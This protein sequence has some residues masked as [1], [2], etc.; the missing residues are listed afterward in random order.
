M[1][2]IFLNLCV[3]SFIILAG[4]VSQRVTTVVGCTYNESKNQTDYFVIPFGSVSIPGKWDKSNYNSM[5]GQQFFK[6]NDSISIAIAFT[7]YDKYE[8]NRDGK[9]KGFD[10]VSAYYE[11]DSKYFVDSYGLNRKVVISD[12]VNNFIL[13]Q[14]YGTIKGAKFDT[15]FL[16]GEKNGFVKNF[17]ISITNKWAEE[18]KVQFL[19]GLYIKE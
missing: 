8:F 9:K 3:I 10:F 13:Y 15:Y 5:S 11:W 7:G 16:I 6:N 1:K 12:S 4:C 14:L 18:A 19:K 17:S 2:K